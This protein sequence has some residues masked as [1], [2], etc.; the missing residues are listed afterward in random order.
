MRESSQ[1]FYSVCMSAVIIVF[2]CLEILEIWSI[3]SDS[4]VFGTGVLCSGLI[5][6]IVSFMGYVEARM[7]EAQEE[8]DRLMEI[9]TLYAEGRE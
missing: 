3:S 4:L 5:L 6:M 1:W 2:G 8:L 9:M 7:D